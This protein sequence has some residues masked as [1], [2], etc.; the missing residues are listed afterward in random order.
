MDTLQDFLI[1]K[2]NELSLSL[3]DA[4]KIIGI[5][6]SY[7]STLE[8]GFESG[9]NTPVKPTPETLQLISNAYDVPYETLM[10]FSGYLH[11]DTAASQKLSEKDEKDIA[12]RLENLRKDLYENSE[13][14][15]FSGEPLSQEA[16]ESILDA[17]ALGVRQAKRLNK[18]FTPKKFKK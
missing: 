9:K 17:L 14:L 11:E 12:K 10:R 6:H 3:R 7:L 4:A 8:K 16:K 18:K 1:N 13:G 15:M 5:S 2:R